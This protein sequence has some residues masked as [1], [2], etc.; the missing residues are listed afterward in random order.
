MEYLPCYRIEPRTDLDTDLPVV[1][2][3]GLPYIA[4]AV[5]KSNRSKAWNIIDVEKREFLCQLRMSE[6]DG[7]LLRQA[8]DLDI[9]PNDG[10]IERTSNRP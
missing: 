5:T 4:E 7:W 3:P 8:R 1:G 10:Y 2:I 9:P 6:R